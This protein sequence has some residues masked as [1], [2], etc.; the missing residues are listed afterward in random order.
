MTASAML[1][2]EI[3]TTYSKAPK[4]KTL[5]I[6]VASD[7]S[8]AA[9]AAFKAA[10]L[11]KARNDA[12]IHVLTVLEPMP[13]MFFSLEG[14]VVPPELNQSREEAQRAMVLEQMMPFDH[15]SE[16]SLDVR[17]GRAAESIV[18]FA[19]E[20][21]ADLIIVGLHKHGIVGR[22][23]GEETAMEIARLSSVPLFIASPEIK[24]LPR[25][26]MVAMDL[27]PESLA[28]AWEALAPVADTPSISCV[29]V[30]PRSEFLGVDWIEFDKEYELAMHERFAALEKNL[31][32]V[33]LRP[34]L[35][36][37]HGDVAREMADFASYS[38]AELLVV[39]I[40][41]RSGRARA[42][43]GRVATRI[44]RHAECS[45]LVVPGVITER[46]T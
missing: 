6:A 34:D 4:T 41:R 37:L 25:R 9:F 11:I 18:E 28:Q 10:R 43:S 42:T 17:T 30:K 45:V 12:A 35:I 31:E 27:R 21:K 8:E 7:G 36:V 32:L 26:I 24:R 20:S 23:L 38:K 13:R 40:R 19:A 22:I 46:E 3:D 44:V 14:I 33:N 15:A 16:W 29:H 1:T 39:G 2:R 5:S